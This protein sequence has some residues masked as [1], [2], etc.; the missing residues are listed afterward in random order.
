[1][2][3]SDVSR[4]TE[5][6]HTHLTSAKISSINKWREKGVKGLLL[7]GV[8]GVGKSLIANMICKSFGEHRM[9]NF[10]NVL[11][12]KPADIRSEMNCF[13]SQ[14]STLNVSCF[15]VADDVYRLN[16]SDQIALSQAFDSYK[17]KNKFI[18]TSCTSSQIIPEVLQRF[19]HVNISNPS[20]KYLRCLIS[21]AW[22]SDIHL[23]TSCV[24]AILKNC[25]CSIPLLL[26]SL[27]KLHILSCDMTVSDVH[28][29]CTSVD[30]SLCRKFMLACRKKKDLNSGLKALNS[31]LRMGISPEDVLFSLGQCLRIYTDK[32]LVG[33]EEAYI[34]AVDYAALTHCTK[35]AIY[36]FAIQLSDNAQIN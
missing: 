20:T 31:L 5:L 22:T 35:T 19:V 17:H 26:T 8:S 32:E 36:Y 23:R 9:Y 2:L 14:L 10:G 30:L 12:T 29:S 25:N 21:R 3:P 15:V 6:S 13:C 4:P 7:T 11:S 33:A 34:A 16:D 1:M 24:N 18:V 27:D 28:E